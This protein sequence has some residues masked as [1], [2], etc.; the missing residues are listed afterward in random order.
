MKSSFRNVLKRKRDLKIIRR[1]EGQRVTTDDSDKQ[2]PKQDY[3]RSVIKKVKYEVMYQKIFEKFTTK[4]KIS[5]PQDEKIILMRQ[6]IQKLQQFLK[7]KSK[8]RNPSDIT[9]LKIFQL[10]MS[11]AHTTLKKI[12]KHNLVDFFDVEKI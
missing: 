8:E 3:L 2:A 7:D 5:Q 9:G 4:G 11:L 6:R 10:V 12:E 1:M